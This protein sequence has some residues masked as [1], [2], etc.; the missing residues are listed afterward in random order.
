MQTFTLKSPLDMHL[1][2]RDGDMLSLVAPYSAEEFAG[3]VIMP[4]I[5]PP[6]M[7]L[8][9][10]HAYRKRVLAACG[11]HL[12]L[13]YMTMFLKNYDDSFIEEAAAHIIAMKL[14]PAGVTTNS[15]EGAKSIDSLEPQLKAMEALGVPLSVHAETHSPN[16]FLREQNFIPI[17]EYIAKKFPKLKI[18]FEHISSKEGLRLVEEYEN[19]YATITLHHML[20]TV[21]DLMGEKLNPHLFCKPVVKTAAD[22]D[23]VLEAALNAGPKVMF[24]SDSAP[25]PR[26]AKE[27]G[28]AP[29]GIFSAPALLP[30]LLEIFERHGK[31]E[32]L[33]KFIS[34][35][36]QAIYGIKPPEKFVTLEKSS[37]KLP[38][39][40]KSKESEVVPMFAGE[41]CEWRIVGVE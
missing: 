41:N 30:K 20:L 28:S 1:H 16:L 32:N 21:D 2:L 8:D 31:L 29:A 35:N 15:E 13:P 18:M 26:A 24:G 4:N 10:L 36:A 19:I 34:D 25:H 39:V 11:N 33:Q 23:A 22:R 3:G 38:S 5:T 9:A 14:Y 12:F 37:S 40:C 17:L 7:T 6:I 27:S